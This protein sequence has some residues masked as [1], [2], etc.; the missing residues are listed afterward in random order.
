[1][2]DIEDKHNRSYLS[3]ATDILIGAVIG[4]ASGQTIGSSTFGLLMVLLLIT[5]GIQIKQQFTKKK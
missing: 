1:M 4:I 5:S 3:S 2:K